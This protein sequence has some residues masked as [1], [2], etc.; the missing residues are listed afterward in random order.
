MILQK[1][2]MLAGIILVAD[3]ILAGRVGQVACPRRTL[4]SE[5]MR[6]RVGANQIRIAASPLVALATRAASTTPGRP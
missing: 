6:G 4:R 3:M 5:R 1:V 2:T